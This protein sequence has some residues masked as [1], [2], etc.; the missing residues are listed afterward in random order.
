[1]FGCET[2]AQ[3]ME[4]PYCGLWIADRVFGRRRR[5]SGCVEPEEKAAPVV[6]MSLEI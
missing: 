6:T 1:M 5:R 2:S 4:A 3:I